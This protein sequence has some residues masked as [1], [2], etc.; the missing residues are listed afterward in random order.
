MNTFFGIYLFKLIDRVSNSEID[1]QTKA[2][3]IGHRITKVKWN[4][5]GH[6]VKH[7]DDRWSK[8]TTE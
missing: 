1:R 5:V 7:I 8:M 3:D 6:I 2:Q 4:R